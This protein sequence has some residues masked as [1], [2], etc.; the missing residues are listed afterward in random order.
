VEFYR[1][2]VEISQ[3]SGDKRSEAN[4]LGGLGNAYNS[5]GEYNRAIEYHQQSLAIQRE[6]GD[7][8][9]DSALINSLANFMETLTSMETSLDRTSA[10]AAN[11][12]KSIEA[13]LPNRDPG[14]DRELEHDRAIQQLV[15]AGLTPD[16]R[17]ILK[18]KPKTPINPTNSTIS[19]KNWLGSTIG[20]LTNKKPK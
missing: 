14:R 19:K 12:Y 18:P 9:S 7:R 20:W 16:P 4:A 13:D 8:L 17:P 10:I 3:E 6:V 1:Q 5:L 15:D 11:S 2:W